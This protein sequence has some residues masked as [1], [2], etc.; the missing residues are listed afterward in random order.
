MHAVNVASCNGVTEWMV[1]IVTATSIE[2]N[3]RAIGPLDIIA[4]VRVH[5]V[6]LAAVGNHNP[7]E[8]VALRKHTLV[9]EMSH[10]IDQLWMTD[11]TMMTLF[12]ES[13]LQKELI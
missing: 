10:T 3:D 1:G 6:G 9:Y 12:M 5:C 2:A 7:L 13:S 8:G 11:A 4:V